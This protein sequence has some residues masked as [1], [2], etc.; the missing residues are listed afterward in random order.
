MYITFTDE[1]ASGA[2]GE[3][4]NVLQPKSGKLVLPLRIIRW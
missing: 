4:P 1:V 3:N 2:S